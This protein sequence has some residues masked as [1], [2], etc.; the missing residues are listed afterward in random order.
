MHWYRHHCVRSVLVTLI[1]QRSHT[2]S[3]WLNTDSTFLIFEV[4]QIRYKF[5]D[6]HVSVSFWQHCTVSRFLKFLLCLSGF[7]LTPSSSYEARRKAISDFG[8]L[9]RFT[10]MFT[11]TDD[12]DMQKTP[13][14][15]LLHSY[16]HS[17]SG[18]FPWPW[19]FLPKNRAVIV[20]FEYLNPHFIET[21]QLERRSL[22]KSGPVHL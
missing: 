22:S 9:E 16:F 2:A 17:F 10:A 11:V 19:A 7:Y 21:W 12:T 14:L 8:W 5:V 6:P 18:Y 13:L 15:K 4:I 20:E 1:P 3:Q